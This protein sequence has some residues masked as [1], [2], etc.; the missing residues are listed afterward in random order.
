MKTHSRWLYIIATCLAGQCLW[1][2]GAGCPDPPPPDPDPPV[3]TACGLYARDCVPLSGATPFALAA[4]DF[5]RDGDVDL[6][7][8]NLDR[9]NV[10]ILVNAGDASFTDA[11][12]HAVGD[13]PVSIA[14][15]DWDGDGDPDLSV[16][17]DRAVSVL[18]N[19]GDATFAPAIN[20]ASSDPPMSL[21]AADLDGN[22]ALDLVTANAFLDSI[23]AFLNDGSGSFTMQ[24]VLAGTLAAR[25]SAI[26]AADVNGDGLPD[27]IVS[28]ST[29]DVIVLVNTGAGEFAQ[30][31]EVS[32]GQGLQLNG[33]T[34]E[35]LD[36]DGD[37]DVVVVVS[38]SG[39]DTTEPGSLALLFNQGG[40]TFDPPV[41]VRAGTYPTSVVATDLDG[42]GDPDL[43]VANNTSDDVSIILNAGGG[44]FGEPQSVGVGE[45][46]AFVVAADFDADGD[47]DL[48]VA[49][50]ASD[51]VAILL[52]HGGGVFSIEP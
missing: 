12:N 23:T 46:P 27:L 7:V 30:P 36:L 48:A 15:G 11:G 2:L 4:D 44:V 16:A 50:M 49:N 40:G 25:L 9:N 34:I 29:D 31:A 1:L 19:Q 20:V 17:G 6:A 24:A 38:R 45:G 51:T 41:Q 21:T 52:N 28:R 47:E 43:A 33:L 35:D 14:S 37:E 42:D 32:V 39:T 3:A 5:D 22:G 10:T 26:A 8:V 13:K 18:V